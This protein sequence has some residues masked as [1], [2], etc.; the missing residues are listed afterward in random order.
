MSLAVKAK[1]QCGQHLPTQTESALPTGQ[2]VR[3]RTSGAG[4][5]SPTIHNGRALA[6]WVAL[7][8]LDFG[9]ERAVSGLFAGLWH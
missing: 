8:S 3:N 4:S 9:A 7:D 2:P 6:G 5:V 1:G